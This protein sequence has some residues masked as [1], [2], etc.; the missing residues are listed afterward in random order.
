MKTIIIVDRLAE[1]GIPYHEW[2]TPSDGQ[3]VLFTV[4]PAEAF[5]PR[6]RSA[7][8]AAGDN[9]RMSTRRAS[10]TNQ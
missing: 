4:R 9:R 5:S 8:C 10:L 2:F 1:A 3:L 6:I 7:S